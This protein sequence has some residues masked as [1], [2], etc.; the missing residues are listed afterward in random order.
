LVSSV[1]SASCG[2]HEDHRHQRRYLF[3]WRLA[4]LAE[5]ANQPPQEWFIDRVCAGARSSFQ[6]SSARL[7]V[8]PN[9]AVIAATAATFDPNSRL[10]CQR[11]CRRD[12]RPASV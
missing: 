12:R 10:A 11:D 8:F 7:L 5:Q 6:P 4:S 2:D 1:P 9:H 3:N